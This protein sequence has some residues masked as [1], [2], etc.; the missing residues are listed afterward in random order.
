MPSAPARRPFPALR[1]VVLVRESA[2]RPDAD[3]LGAFV[4]DRDADAFAVLV[5]RHGPMVLGVC[6]RVVGDVHTA[7]DAF[8]AVFLVLARRAA[9]VRPRAAVGN[10]LYGVAYRTALKARAVRARRHARF[11]QVDAMPEPPA[12][13]PSDPWTDLRPV[14][15]EELA[16]LPDKYRLPVVLCD[17]EGRPQRAVAKHLGVAPA[18][19]AGR[20]AQARRTLAAR[21]TRRGVTLSGGAVA[22]LLTERASA[23]AVGPAL[24]D[25]VVRAAEAVAAGGVASGFVSA[26]ALNLCEGVMRMMLLT[27]LKAAGAGAL[28][29]LALTGGL[30]YGPGLVRAGDGS[31]GDQGVNTPRSPNNQDATFLDR[32]STELRGDKATPVEHGYFAKDPDAAKRKKV[33]EWFL[34]D[35]AVKAHQ[36]R[37]F[38]GAGREFRL[39]EL[40][41]APDGTRLAAGN[42]AGTVTVWDVSPSLTETT[43]GSFLLGDIVNSNAG[44]AGS[45]TLN[46][47]YDAATGRAVV[48]FDAD[49]QPDVLVFKYPD[50]A[51]AAVT[52]GLAYLNQV[53]D[54]PPAAETPRGG[55]FR[56]WSATPPPGAVNPGALAQW[57]PAGQPN[58]E[59]RWTE[60]VNG[61]EPAAGAEVRYWVQLAQPH[62]DLN[63]TYRRVRVRAA[64]ELRAADDTD[65][66]FLE[67]AVKAA[68]GTAPSEVEKKY[69]ADDKDPKKREKLLDLLLADPAVAKKLG[70][71]WK[72]T[73]LTPPATTARLHLYQPAERLN[74]NT[75]ARLALTPQGETVW[76][77]QVRP[78][79]EWTYRAVITAP[80]D[81]F[82]KLVDE[83]LGANRTDEQVLE[84]VTLAAA[85]R[86]PTDPERRLVLAT[87]GK[88]ADKKAAWVE[89]AK[90]LAPAEE[91][92]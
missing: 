8:Q 11:K 15:D 90:A 2:H 48:D 51:N 82:G 38:T 26:H 27:K 49:G 28:A 20:L 3:L 14:I 58:P 35:P 5:R 57:Q 16:R 88:A 59:A 72:K 41:F 17:L 92:K 84:A 44:V 18:T 83:L 13:P 61:D 6:R 56:S 50:Q 80:P 45:V 43:S 7:D 85:G 37:K 24:A 32:L 52:R 74:L 65:E 25:G 69:F 79:Q 71:D 42:A 39:A 66:A 23:G 19:L 46:E 77:T 62:A 55:F 1:R 53:Q 76:R 63:T 31:G 68:R 60:R 73:M 54:N 10:W 89:V 9:A 78:L 34:A 22:T 70:D 30:G 21:L 33:V 81:K 86:L 75:T 87:I 64:D 40:A 47:R 67:R 91:K 12:P 29:V 4:R 36:A